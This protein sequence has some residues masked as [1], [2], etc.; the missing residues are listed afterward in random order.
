MLLRCLEQAS[1]YTRA[2]TPE[3]RTIC[4]LGRRMARKSA[5]RPTEAVK[6]AV[7][8]LAVEQLEALVREVELH[9]LSH[10]ERTDLWRRLDRISRA[11]RNA[12]IDD[13]RW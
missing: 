4:M 7:L 9:R 13:A 1:A 8:A 2:T 12:V 6:A 5:S 3:I 10:E 11:L